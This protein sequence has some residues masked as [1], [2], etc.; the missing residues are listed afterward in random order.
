MSGCLIM[1]LSISGSGKLVV[2]AIE[3]T[4]L[5]SGKPHA[6]VW[7]LCMTIAFAG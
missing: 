2:V 5:Y 4:T 1:V 3:D 7:Y 6:E